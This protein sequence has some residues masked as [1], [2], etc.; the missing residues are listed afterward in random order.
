MTLSEYKKKH[1]L[2]N[3]ELAKQFDI[4]HITVS[5]LLNDHQRPSADTLDKLVHYSGGE[6]QYSDYSSISEPSSMSA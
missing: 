5:R 2:L 6:I 1:G 4:S 3:T